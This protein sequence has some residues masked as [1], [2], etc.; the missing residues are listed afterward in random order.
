[1]RLKRIIQDEQVA[2]IKENLDNAG[3]VETGAI[4]ELSLLG[5]AYEAHSQD[6]TGEIDTA[7]PPYSI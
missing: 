6:S 5:A 4:K 2:R 7:T 1:L 3:D